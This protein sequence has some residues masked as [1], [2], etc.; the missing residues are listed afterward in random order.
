[1]QRI[2]VLSILSATIIY[3]SGCSEPTT[4]VREVVSIPG[5][6][7]PHSTN[8]SDQPPGQLD[9]ATETESPN[10]V[11]EECN[12]NVGGCSQ[13]CGVQQAPH[14]VLSLPMSEESGVIITD[15][16]GHEHSGRVLGDFER[17]DSPC[18]SAL[19]FNGNNTRVQIPNSLASLSGNAVT[20]EAWIYVSSEE[21]TYYPHLLAGGNN[22]YRL[23]LSPGEN[24]LRLLWRLE[25]D[26]TIHSVWYAPTSLPTEQ[27][28]HLAGTYDGNEMVLFL[29]A[30]PVG[31]KTV[32][33]R[34]DPAQD[35]EL[36]SWDQ[37]EQSF[38]TGAL[39]EIRVWDTV[40][41]PQEICNDGGGRWLNEDCAY[42]TL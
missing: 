29:N 33:G 8:N 4:I 38:F 31:R 20:L 11:N 9:P 1:M 3:N 37:I 10:D 7:P 5:S 24:G 18:G 39:D 30:N 6:P 28:F 22:N 32:S 23:S 34:I 41:A 26:G 21:T 40:R 35:L 27:W 2:I 17:L 13:S 15:T 14:L 36:G 12:S 16:S 42:P 25:I 19:S